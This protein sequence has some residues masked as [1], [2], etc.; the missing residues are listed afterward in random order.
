[1]IGSTKPK[2]G[3]LSRADLP[4]R[5]RNPDSE[6]RRETASNRYFPELLD[7]LRAQLPERCVLDGEIVIVKNDGLDFDALPN[8]GFIRPASRVKLLSGQMPA[9]VVFFDL[10][11]EGDRDLRGEPFQTRRRELESLLSTAKPPIHLTPRQP[12]TR[13]SRP[14]G[15]DASKAP[16]STASWPSPFPPGTYEPDKRVM[17][18]IKHER[19]CDCVVAGFPGGTRKGSGTLGRLRCLS[20]PFASNGV[21]AR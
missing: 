2:W 17:L 8:S 12:T 15:F 13:P 10:L 14:I 18:K 5:R 6:P 1:M 3:R 7:P 11:C 4:R 16:G 9:S 21:P 19:D 20:Q